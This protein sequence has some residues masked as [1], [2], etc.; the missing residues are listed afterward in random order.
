MTREDELKEALGLALRYLDDGPW[1]SDEFVSMAMV[2]CDIAT[3][4][5]L[6]II[7]KATERWDKNP[8]VR[9][10]VDVV[11]SDAL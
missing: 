5:A 9:P 11:F 7:R 8:P 1:P 10:S 6:E 4:E 3:P 2:E